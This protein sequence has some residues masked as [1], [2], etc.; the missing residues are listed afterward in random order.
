MEQ[1]RFNEIFVNPLNAAFGERHKKNP[2]WSRTFYAEL[3]DSVGNFSADTLNLA[4]KDLRDSSK[5]WPSIKEA[6]TACFEVLKRTKKVSAK[7]SL[8]FDDCRDIS[9][10]KAAKFLEDFKANNSLWQ[11]SVTEKWDTLL[12]W[13]VDLFSRPLFTILAEIDDG[14]TEIIIDTPPPFLYK[15]IPYTTSDEILKNKY[16]LI[17]IELIKTKQFSLILDAETI[18]C[19]KDKQMTHNDAKESYYSSK[20]LV[21][22][23]NVTPEEDRRKE[24]AA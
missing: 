7:K 3:Y 13:Y 24:E 1:A 8:S 5:Y 15:R 10:T 22:T 11:Q 18:S 2:Q 17:V 14:K 4:A 12:E 16:D 6:K 21:D 19:L 23:W 9:A 20:S